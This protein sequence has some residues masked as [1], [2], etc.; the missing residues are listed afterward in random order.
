MYTA[1][2]LRVERVTFKASHLED[3]YA[4]T[5]SHGRSCKAHI[6]W[7]PRAGTEVGIGLFFDIS[8]AH[9]FPREIQDSVTP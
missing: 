6:H 2:N 4:K 3:A 1:D 8:F 7:L 5:Y 9:L